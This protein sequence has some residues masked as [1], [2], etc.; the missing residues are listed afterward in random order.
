MDWGNLG[1]L[2]RWRTAPNVGHAITLGYNRRMW[3]QVTLYQKTGNVA[4]DARSSVIVWHAVF[5]DFLRYRG[6][7]AAAVPALPGADTK[8]RLSRA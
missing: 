2:E 5:L 4:A 8:A 1:H 3:A 7:R 6:F